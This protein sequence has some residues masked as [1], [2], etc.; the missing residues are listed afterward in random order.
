MEQQPPVRIPPQHLDAAA[1]RSIV[2]EI[3]SRDGTEFSDHETKI[4]TVLGLISRG[5]V[6][7]WFDP[8]T[9]SCSVR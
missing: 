9:A 7:I 1:L 8:N 3:V 5:E 4:E 2:E 6:E